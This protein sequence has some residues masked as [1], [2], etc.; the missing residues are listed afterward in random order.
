MLRDVEVQDAPAIMTDDEKA[1]EH[2]ERDRWDREE[3]H[4]GDSFPMVVQ[5]GKPTLSWLGI[6]WRSFHPTGDRSLGEI[7]TE[8]EEFTMDARRTP[9]RIFGNHSEDQLTNFFRDSSSPDLLTNSG[10]QFPIQT[11]PR[12][13][14]TDNSFWC[15]DDESLFPSC[16]ESTNG[17]P[18]EPVDECQPRS[19][20][21]TFQDRELLA[22]REILQD[23]AP[24][25]TKEANKRSKGESVEVE[26][27][28][29]L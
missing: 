1:V 3:I 15:D 11:E 19:R 23:K 10:D 4:C 13:M 21:T 20:M 29:D 16:P 7:K 28:L 27:S 14:P 25:T 22:E 26:H 9:R 18:E 2:A 8:H 24:T 6:S 17:D 5:K 12:S